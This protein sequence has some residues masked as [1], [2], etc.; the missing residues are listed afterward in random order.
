M[1]NDVAVLQIQANLIV[2]IQSEI[3]D[4]AAVDLQE[5]VL[6]RVE[7]CGAR[8]LVLDVSALGL[9]DSF[10]ARVLMETSQMARM[11]NVDAVIAGMKPEIALTLIQMGFGLDGVRTAVDLER[12]LEI[13]NGSGPAVPP[14]D[15]PW[16]G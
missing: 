12:G 15:D 5:A 3:T 2:S 7:R 8:G 4:R 6:R 16:A 13:L 14:E 10:I 9:I 1:G 11:M